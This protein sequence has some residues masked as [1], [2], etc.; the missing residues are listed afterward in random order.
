LKAKFDYFAITRRGPRPTI[1]S[2]V[3]ACPASAVQVEIN[4][5]VAD[6]MGFKA[7][8]RAM[9]NAPQKGARKIKEEVPCPFLTGSTHIQ[10]GK[11]NMHRKNVANVAIGVGLFVFTAAKMGWI[12]M[13]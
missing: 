4:I 11:G 8:H 12:A 13:R 1:S 7:P 10:P 9:R 5:M 3:G 2:A 6:F